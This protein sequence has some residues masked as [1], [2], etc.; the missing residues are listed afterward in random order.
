MPI[1]LTV[2]GLRNRIARWVRGTLGDRLLDNKWERAMRCLEEATELAQSENVTEADALRIVLRVYK[3]PV[4]NPRQEAS[5]LGVCFL[6]YCASTGL[7][8]LEII[9]EEL[10]RIE[11]IEKSFFMKKQT[12][13]ADAGVGLYPGDV[14]F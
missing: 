4:G 12:D 11:S 7:K 13:K 2:E 3:R 9:N 10:G 8:P 1:E 14:Q 5:G 6:A